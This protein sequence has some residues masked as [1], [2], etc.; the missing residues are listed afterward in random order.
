MSLKVEQR[1]HGNQ[2]AEHS[3]QIFGTGVYLVPMKIM[4]N[5]ME[6]FVWVANEF[7][8]DTYDNTGKCISPQ[9]ISD[10]LN[11]LYGK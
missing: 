7:S 3:Q 6:K 1:L 2:F 11:D 8:D 9:I 5:G 10:T 4:V